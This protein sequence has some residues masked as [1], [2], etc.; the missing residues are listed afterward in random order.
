MSQVEI[1][2]PPASR[3]PT[4]V[5]EAVLL[6]NPQLLQSAE[7]V[8]ENRILWSTSLGSFSRALVVLQQPSLLGWRSRRRHL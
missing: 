5:R 8:C 7:S 1:S 2:V 6:W 3:G 4:G